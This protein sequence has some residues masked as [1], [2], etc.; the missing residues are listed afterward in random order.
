MGETGEHSLGIGLGGRRRW[1]AGC[2]R[3]AIRLHWSPDNRRLRRDSICLGLP[4]RGR[5]RALGGRSIA[6]PP[7]R[8][9]NWRSACGSQGSTF[10]EKERAY[11][12]LCKQAI[13][14][15]RNSPPANHYCHSV[16]PP[17]SPADQTLSR[18]LAL[19]DGWVVVLDPLHPL[20]LRLGRGTATRTGFVAT[21]RAL[22]NA[23]VCV[24]TRLL[25]SLLDLLNRDRAAAA[26]GGRALA[27]LRRRRARAVCPGGAAPIKGGRRGGARRHDGKGQGAAVRR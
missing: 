1:R 21:A 4:C 19:A 7:F 5:E 17:V 2:E 26:A 10:H 27:L 9:H 24:R 18:R 11:H 22:A 6:R 16:R 3:S 20:L 15:S 14:V 23:T 13:E 12:L 8:G 25:H